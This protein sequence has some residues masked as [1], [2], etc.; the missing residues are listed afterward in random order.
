MNKFHLIVKDSDSDLKDL[1]YGST[2][3]RRFKKLGHIC[4]G[5]NKAWITIKKAFLTKYSF[6]QF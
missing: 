6:L 3:I 1:N 4:G 5:L 2:K